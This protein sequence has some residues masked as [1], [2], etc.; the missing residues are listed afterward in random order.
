LSIKNDIEM[1]KEELTSEEKF[2]EKSVITERFV[3]K[4]K[5]ILIAGV[6]FIVVGVTGNIVY[7][8]NKEETAK[9]AN[10]VLSSL[11]ANPSDSNALAQL[12]S[13]SPALHDVYIY[14]KAIADKDVQTL[15]SL[16]DSK[17]LPLAD[18]IRYELAQN[19]KDVNELTAYAL[20]QDAIYK[21]LA[22]VQ[23]AI[24]LMN[25]AQTDKAHSKLQTI[26]EVSPLSKIAKALLH[27]G[28][29]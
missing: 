22:Q 14:S 13:L 9:E 19:N 21:D 28:V 3:K 1:I 5:N 10:V 25:D 6:A 11:Q 23:A 8:I 7:D 18:L 17:V 12:K 20:A 29:K 2:F 4:Y 15:E 16:K 26:E 27:Y 24:I